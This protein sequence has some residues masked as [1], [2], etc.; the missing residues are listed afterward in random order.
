M[1]YFCSFGVFTSKEASRWFFCCTDDK[2]AYQAPRFSETIPVRSDMPRISKNTLRNSHERKTSGL[3]TCNYFD[4]PCR[5]FS[6]IFPHFVH[7][8]CFF[9]SYEVHFWGLA[10]QG[11][12]WCSCLAAP[13]HTNSFIHKKW[14]NLHKKRRSAVRWLFHFE[15]WALLWDL[16][17]QTSSWHSRDGSVLL[18]LQIVLQTKWTQDA[19]SVNIFE[20]WFQKNPCHKFFIQHLFLLKHVILILEWDSAL[21][22]L[23]DL[24]GYSIRLE[25]KRSFRTKILVCTTG[26]FCQLDGRIWSFWK[27]QTIQKPCPKAD[28]FRIKQ[29]L[30]PSTGLLESKSLSQRDQI[31]LKHQQTSTNI[32]VFVA[33]MNCFESDILQLKR[34]ASPTVGKWSSITQC[35]A[36]HCRRMLCPQAIFW[37][38]RCK[39]N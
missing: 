31:W 37:C 14:S 32:S 27:G 24:V 13:H 15:H 12:C 36:Y 11:P 20:L 35:D 26:Q 34:C 38:E 1:L 17:R 30:S 33:C 22:G 9:S 4:S 29:K 25:S 10:C 7:F 2:H 28:V 3:F 18:A 16:P 21:S 6:W 8:T 23:G 19:G 39:W 5:F